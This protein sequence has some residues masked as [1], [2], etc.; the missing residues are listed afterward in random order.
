MAVD[1]PEPDHV[2]EGA[3]DLDAVELPDR[4]LI[5]G[6]DPDVADTQRRKSFQH[7]ICPVGLN[8]PSRQVSSNEN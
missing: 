6:R 4:V 1:L 5:D 2:G 7:R 3:L 8:E